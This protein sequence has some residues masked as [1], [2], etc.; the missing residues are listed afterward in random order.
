MGQRYRRGGASLGPQKENVGHEESRVMGI[1]GQV[2]G[3]KAISV[4]LNGDA[5]KE[6]G[7]ELH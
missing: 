3:N 2:E 7:G 1:H 5:A 4:N 6:C